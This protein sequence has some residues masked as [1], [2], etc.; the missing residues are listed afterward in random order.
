M[1]FSYSEA[2]RRPPAPRDE[3]TVNRILSQ[4][5]L[6]GDDVETGKVAGW[7]ESER[8]RRRSRQFSLKYVLLATGFLC[9]L[10]AVLHG[11]RDLDDAPRRIL[12]GVISVAY[13]SCV[14]AYPHV[15]RKWF[16]G[17]QVIN[18]FGIVLGLS[19]VKFGE[20]SGSPLAFCAAI[21]FFAACF[22]VGSTAGQPARRG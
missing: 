1:P 13:L 4:E 12:L 5:E 18:A 21:G 19:Y 22:L 20:S 6:S 2:S 11:A 7:L 14:V 15:P 16:F 3:D 10:L 17:I 8:G 9:A